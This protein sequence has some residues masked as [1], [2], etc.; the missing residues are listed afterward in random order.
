MVIEKFVCKMKIYFAGAITASR[1]LLPQ[2]KLIVETLE[3]EGNVVLS[4]HVA[5]S[6]YQIGG[7]L[8]P[9]ELYKEQMELVGKAEVLVAEVSIPSFGVSF[10]ISHALSKHIPVLAMQYRE[11][12]KA[13][14]MVRGNPDLYF[15]V[16]TEEN[17]HL[18]L[19]NFLKHIK[20]SRARKGK[21]VVFEGGDGSGKTTQALLFVDK[22]KKE[23]IPVKYIEFPR[24]YTS[25]H[26][27]VVG[28]YLKGEFGSLENTSSYLVALAYAIDRAGA[29]EE[30]EDFLESGGVVVSNRYVSSSKAYFAGKFTTEKEQREFISWLDELEYKVHKIPREDL[31]VYLDVSLE[32]SQR[33]LENR[34]KRTYS[35]KDKDLHE[36]NLEY[37]KRV[38]KTYR[39]LA[40]SLNWELISCINNGNLLTKKEVQE[41]IIEVMR[42]RKII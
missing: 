42:E 34:G 2:Y 19:S 28:R 6:A 1:E 27:E 9:A 32:V 39:Q 23:K 25:F 7:G 10:L 17:I 41:K 13:S 4:K 24:Y 15:E 20:K 5:D 29:K 36:A 26:G 3:K 11:Q 40:K 12:E 38:E 14:Y 21:L 33:L 8:T 22:L 30:I 18:V 31:V 37:L 35:G 16:Y